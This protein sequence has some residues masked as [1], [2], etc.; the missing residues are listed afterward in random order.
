MILLEQRAIQRYA[1]HQRRRPRRLCWAL[2]RLRPRGE[3]VGRSILLPRRASKGGQCSFR[4]PR[5]QE[6]SNPGRTPPPKHRASIFFSRTVFDL[7][8]TSQTT[9]SYS[10]SF[11]TMPA[12]LL[13]SGERTAV[14]TSDLL[15]NRIPGADFSSA[16]AGQRRK[17]KWRSNASRSLHS[18]FDKPIATVKRLTNADRGGPLSQDS[19]V[20]GRPRARRRNESSAPRP[21]PPAAVEAASYGPRASPSRPLRT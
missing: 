12:R 9:K 21:G 17:M 3:L 1:S 7:F 19:T 18:P 20:G 4:R 16:P 13:P 11:S 6:W 14:C 8:G 5:P 2:G 15:S 10:F